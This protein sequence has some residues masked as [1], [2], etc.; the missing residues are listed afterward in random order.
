MA[1]S[2][3]SRS[4]PEK[5]NVL[6]I[7]GGGREHA[8]AWRLKKSSSVARLWA[9]HAK[10]N[11]GIAGLAQ[12][13]GFDFSIR[14]LYRVEQFCRHESIDLV[15]VGPEAPLAAGIAE[16]LTTE[17]TKVFGPGAQAAMLEA[18]KSFAKTLMRGASIP[19]AEA[20]V[21]KTPEEARSYL[22]TREEAPV[23]KASGLA[24]GKG[25]FLPETFDDALAAVQRM[26]V[27]KEFGESGSVV[28][29][30][31]RLKGP[32]ASVFALIDGRSI[33]LLD[34]CQDHKRIGDGD[35]GPNTGGMGAYC[36]TPVV[37]GDMLAFVER[38]IVV[39]TVDALRR[40]DI[41]YRGVLYVGLMLT[42]AGPKVLEFNVRFGDPECQCLVRRISGDFGKL[43]YATASGQLE[44]LTPKDVGS[45][46]EH[47]CCVVLASDGYPGPY[48]KGV[49]IEGVEDASSVEGV[50]VFHAGT[51]RAQ[52]GG[53]VTNGGRVLNVVGAGASI[54]EAR[55]RAYR[56][57]GMID[58]A[59]KTMRTDIAHQAIGAQA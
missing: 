39:P 58:F 4:I 37:T 17:Q 43:L 30:E 41:E 34:A 59:G 29:A 13:I 1:R 7:G 52:G 5:L 44:A 27:D 21:L 57:A 32:E 16:K 20:R 38:E 11:P 3:A 10:D 46:G 36:P 54:E 35:T 49:P 26:M 40:E 2:R 55:D 28:I 15:V 9:T 33:L 50:T 53:I 47:V 19:T 14:E 56:A 45:T 22:E 48:R 8:L 23:L 6:L 51:A 25:V 42:P 31:E 18:D 24:A 12:S